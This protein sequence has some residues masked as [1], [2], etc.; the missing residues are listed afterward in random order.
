MTGTKFYRTWCAMKS[1]CYN[2][3]NIEYNH[4][5]GRG[6]TVCEEW[7]DFNN[8]MSDMYESFCNHMNTHDST[9]IERIN[10]NKGYST[11]NCRW[12]TIVEQSRNKT[13]SKKYKLPGYN[14]E[15]TIP[16]IYDLGICDNDLSINT[17]YTRMSRG[18][19]IME[20]I[21]SPNRQYARKMVSFDNTLKKSDYD[22]LEFGHFNGKAGM[23]LQELLEAC[24]KSD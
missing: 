20:A 21:K 2:P 3:N 6:I 17:L 14:R 12:A 5:G 13:T 18:W 16:E 9:T 8:F 24:L 7:L 19:D 11:D 22:Y 4:Y 23:T 15:L 10:V 1:R